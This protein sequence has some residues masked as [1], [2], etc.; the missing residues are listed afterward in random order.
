MYKLIK[1]PFTN[2]VGQVQRLSDT[3]IGRAHV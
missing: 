3:E 1:T 2:E